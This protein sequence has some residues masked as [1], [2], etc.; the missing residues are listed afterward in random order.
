MTEQHAELAVFAAERGA[1]TWDQLRLQWNASHP[2]RGFSDV[3]RFIRD[4]RAAYRRVTGEPL[5][6]KGRE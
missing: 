4:V 1:E 5:N 3:R 6:W 2:D